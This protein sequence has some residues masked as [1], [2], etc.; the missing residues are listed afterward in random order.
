MEG[1]GEEE[2][3]RLEEEGGGEGVGWGGTGEEGEAGGGDGGAALDADEEEDSHTE[4]TEGRTR[5][6]ITSDPPGG[7]RRRVERGEGHTPSRVEESDGGGRGGSE[8]ER[9]R[10]KV[11]VRTLRSV[12]AS[13]T[14]SSPEAADK[15]HSVVE[16]SWTEVRRRGVRRERRGGEAVQLMSEPRF[17]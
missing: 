10:G 14:I 3:E 1:G 16:M 2:D 12:P 11:N 9:E 8:R 13:P 4:E 5:G 7:N 6:H 17:S 15:L